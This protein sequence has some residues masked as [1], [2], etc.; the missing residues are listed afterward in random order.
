MAP[1][2]FSSLTLLYPALSGFIVGFLEVGDFGLAPHNTGE[3]EGLV[4]GLLVGF[5]VGLVVGA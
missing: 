4:V 5:A 3:L 1:T 2:S